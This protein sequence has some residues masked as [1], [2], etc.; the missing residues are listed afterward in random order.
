MFRNNVSY[1]RLSIDFTKYATGDYI[2]LID[3]SCV[4]IIE[5]I[6]RKYGIAKLTYLTKFTVTYEEL[7][8]SSELIDLSNTNHV[9]CRLAE[10]EY[11]RMHMR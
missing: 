6:D 7:K 8:F 4:G 10:R 11:I 1:K 3:E 9:N 2:F 5:D